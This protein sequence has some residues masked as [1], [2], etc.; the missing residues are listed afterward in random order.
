MKQVVIRL[1][2]KLYFCWDAKRG[3]LFLHWIWRTQ[4][5]I[6]SCNANVEWMIYQII[7]KI[8]IENKMPIIGTRIIFHFKHIW[9]LLD[10]SIIN[11][12][13]FCQANLSIWWYEILLEME[14]CFLFSYFLDF[15]IVF[16]KR[17]NLTRDKK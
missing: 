6:C 14:P 11:S 4:T 9:F 16:K 15:V 2:K 5:I 10:H 3:S 1:V 7:K 12:L 8:S 17:R 13:G